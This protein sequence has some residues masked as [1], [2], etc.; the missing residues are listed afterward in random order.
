M[1]PL[2]YDDLAARAVKDGFT[3]DLNGN[4]PTSG[5]AVGSRPDRT[6]RLNL[7]RMSLRD[8]ADGI[9]VYVI[10]NG[11]ELREGY[12]LGAWRDDDTLYLDLVTVTP[13]QGTAMRLARSLGEIAVYNLATHQTIQTAEPPTFDDEPYGSRE[14]A[15]D[16]HQ[17]DWIGEQ[18]AAQYDD[19]PN[20]YHGDY[21]ED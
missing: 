5:Y 21:S 3:V 1:K 18:Y 15:L 20:P 10:D 4:T 16:E 2:N 6:R 9:Y 7:R 17:D 13:D 14:R 12:H 11:Y 19:D 8:V